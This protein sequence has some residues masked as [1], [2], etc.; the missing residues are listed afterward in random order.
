MTTTDPTLADIL[1]PILADVEARIAEALSRLESYRG[2]PTDMG[3]T[4]QHCCQR[5]ER[6]RVDELERVARKLRAAMAHGPEVV[7]VG[8]ASGE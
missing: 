5:V 4:E 2:E 8:F 6:A 1:P 7:A 3:S